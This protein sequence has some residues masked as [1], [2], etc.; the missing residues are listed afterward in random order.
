M[1]RHCL[2]GLRV[3]SNKFKPVCVLLENLY[4]KSD[5]GLNESILTI[6]GVIY[7]IDC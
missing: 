7:S 4:N 2:E 6:L 3:F 5:Q 1:D